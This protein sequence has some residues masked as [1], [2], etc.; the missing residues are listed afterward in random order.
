MTPAGRRDQ[1]VRFE[2]ATTARNALGGKTASAWASLGERWAL[3][4]FGSGSERREAAQE[5]AVQA[6]TFRVLADEVTTTV[7]VADRIV[8]R[9]LTYDVTGIAPIGRGPRE[10]EFTGT[11]A[12]G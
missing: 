8:H 5:G 3:V 12:R 9:G 11:V 6:A 10:L 4:L 7:T 1:V 2:R